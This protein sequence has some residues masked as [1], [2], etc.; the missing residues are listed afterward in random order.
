MTVQYEDGSYADLRK[1]L[2]RIETVAEDDDFPIVEIDF[3]DLAPQKRSINLSAISELIFRVDTDSELGFWSS[4]GRGNQILTTA[5]GLYFSQNK[6]TGKLSC[7]TS[8]AQG[9]TFSTGVSYKF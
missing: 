8:F 9:V 2:A 6:I 4:I 7:H 5:T 3:I 1:E